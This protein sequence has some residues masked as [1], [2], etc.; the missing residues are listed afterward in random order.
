[1]RTGRED[2]KTDPENHAAMADSGGRRELLR[3]CRK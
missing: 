2:K 3:A 1:M